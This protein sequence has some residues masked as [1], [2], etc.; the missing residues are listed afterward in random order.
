MQS[1]QFALDRLDW[2]FDDR[3]LRV[4][5]YRNPRVHTRWT[6]P[7]SHFVGV[8]AALAA[9]SKGNDWRIAHAAGCCLSTDRGFLI[10]G[11]SGAGKSTLVRRLGL[12]QLGDEL[13]RFGGQTD[14][15]WLQ[16]TVVP[17]ELRADHLERRPL[18]AL[19]MPVQSERA[20]RIEPVTAA[21]AATALLSAVVRLEAE[22]LAPDLSWVKRVVDN[23]P[24]YRVHWNLRGDS[25][26]D[27]LV[28]TLE[29]AACLPGS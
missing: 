2:N 28:E 29:A 23:V 26:R 6:V 17:G 25:P 15:F 4:T 5:T 19:L 16:G 3:I 27:A 13:I 8:I 22:D 24:C 20:P 18:S 10:L 1:N 14:D 12:E 11:A 7:W 9:A 21:D